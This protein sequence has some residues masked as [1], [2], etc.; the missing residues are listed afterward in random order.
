MCDPKPL[1]CHSWVASGPRGPTL[2][3]VFTLTSS[4]R[5]EALSGSQGPRG[6]VQRAAAGKETS[7]EKRKRLGAERGAR[8]WSDLDRFGSTGSS[9]PKSSRR[10]HG[11]GGSA[12]CARQA[13]PC[14]ER[15]EHM[16]WGLP[17]GT[18]GVPLRSSCSPWIRANHPG[19]G[20]Q[21]TRPPLGRCL[22]V[23]AATAHSTQNEEGAMNVRCLRQC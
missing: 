22:Y 12:D 16:A 9:A 2:P 10:T 4:P 8:T 13:S 23:Q 7:G 6:M 3:C 11:G 20:A 15:T 14:V 19:Q 17:M 1:S 5:A 18:Q 21:G